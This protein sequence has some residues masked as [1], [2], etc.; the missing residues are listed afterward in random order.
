[1]GAVL[2]GQGGRS[3]GDVPLTCPRSIDMYPRSVEQYLTILKSHISRLATIILREH[4][5]AVKGFGMVS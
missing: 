1:M 2:S 3:R 5:L 4:Y